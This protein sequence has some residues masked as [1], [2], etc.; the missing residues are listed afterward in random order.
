[1]HES[2]VG[3]CGKVWRKCA[4]GKAGLVWVEHG[5]VWGKCEG[6]M[7]GKVWG[8]A[9]LVWVEHGKV[10]GKCEGQKRGQ[11]LAYKLYNETQ[12]NEV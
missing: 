2:G 12:K 5:K 4:W 10:L 11:K 3:R 1:M 6:Q 9:G 7:L 8:K